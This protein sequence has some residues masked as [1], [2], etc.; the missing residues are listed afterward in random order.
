MFPCYLIKWHDYRKE[1]VGHTMGVVIFTTTFVWN[2][3][4]YKNNWARYDQNAC[5][6]S[7]KLPFTLVRISETRTF[8]TYLK[9]ILTIKFH[10]NPYSGSGVPRERTD[11]QTDKTSSRDEHNS[12]FSQFCECALK[13]PIVLLC[14]ICVGLSTLWEKL[15]EFL[16]CHR[17]VMH[18][19]HHC[20]LPFICLL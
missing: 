6:S 2:I 10:E 4:H 13:W 11:R 15:V 5:W 20:L 1:I 14:A 17:F 3:S 12:R 16:Y 18:L 19:V 7:C 8:S 9:K